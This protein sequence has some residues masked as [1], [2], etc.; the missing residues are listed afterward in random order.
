MIEPTIDDEPPGPAGS[1]DDGGHSTTDGAA[2]AFHGPNATTMRDVIEQLVFDRRGQHVPRYT[3]H[4]PIMPDVWIGLALGAREG[5]SLRGQHSL[6]LTP[7]RDAPTTALVPTLRQRIATDLAAR[8]SRRTVD[9][10]WLASN[11]SS[12]AM[13]GGLG[14][15]V[16]I[17]LPATSWWQRYIEGFRRSPNPID[18]PTEGVDPAAVQAAIA[19]G[20]VV[21]GRPDQVPARCRD[22]LAKSLWLVEQ[23]RD[24]LV[25]RLLPAELV[26][27]VRV[28]GTI[29]LLRK[30][31]AALVDEHGCVASDAV[32][33]LAGRGGKPTRALATKV[34]ES[35]LE[36]A[37][38]VAP[39]PAPPALPA[40]ESTSRSPR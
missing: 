16:R 24:R 29:A 13:N 5:R 18:V 34:V 8:R 20:F 15:L 28:V 37:R 12:V 2:P 30:G 22:S 39:H 25:Y 21:R 32:L 17:L 1:S 36:V 9:D 11:E 33:R 31:D 19:D 10:A 26:W 40:R 4:S 14:D 35:F 3:Q 27:L 6:L 38:H 23:G 7:H